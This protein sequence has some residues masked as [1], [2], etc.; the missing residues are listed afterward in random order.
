MHMAEAAFQS[1]PASIGN[2]ILSR[3]ARHSTTAAWHTTPE[4]PVSSSDVT[5]TLL[6]S[7]DAVRCIESDWVDLYR[8]CARPG[9][10]FQ[11]F[12][13]LAAWLDA[14]AGTPG[15]DQ[16][17]L[18]I[19][20]RNGRAVLIAPFALRS[21][22][23]LK[24]LTWMGEPAIQ[25]GDILV[26]AGPEARALCARA[27]EEAIRGL[28]PDLV[29]F[30]RVRADSP[31]S[32]TLGTSGFETVE[33]DAAPYLDFGTTLTA[34][35]Y[36]ERYPAKARR[37]RR[38]LLRRLDETHPVSFIRLPA[39]PEAARATLAAL[40]MKRAWLLSRAEVSPALADDR[41]ARWF[42]ALARNPD[43]DCRVTEMRC[44]GELAAAQIGFRD[45]DRLSLYLIVFGLKFEKDGVGTLH[46]E[47]TIREAFEE[48]IRSIDLLAPNVEYKR[49]WADDTVALADFVR[50]RTALGHA[51]AR[52]YLMTGRKLAK[53]TLKALPSGLRN[54]I[55]RYLRR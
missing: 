31:L 15:A 30:R 8:R 20:R 45:G 4:R 11:H 12:H 48:G 51:Y 10:A 25:Y 27:I 50:P 46:L 24:T 39:G 33:H 6:T 55:N 1:L 21:R 28:R 41:I 54:T 17:A 23:G 49:K 29:H 9:Q 52:G 3:P 42:E 43:C 35:D 2:D 26:D 18:V 22:L 14:Y 47:R 34:D 32:A 5:F 37:N 13:R 7:A 36:E 16:P 38:R 53:R 19:A 44:N 40:S